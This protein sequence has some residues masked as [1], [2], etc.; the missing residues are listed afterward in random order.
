MIVS[1]TFFLPALMQ[2]LLLQLPLPRLPLL[3]LL[4]L[5]LLLLLRC[6]RAAPPP[7]LKREGSPYRHEKTTPE[8][9]M[10][11]SNDTKVR[12]HRRERYVGSRRLRTR[13]PNSTP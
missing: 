8:S 6:I 11:I 5:L 1:L 4:R 7:H 3:L 12:I 2:L 10:S 13:L 9:L